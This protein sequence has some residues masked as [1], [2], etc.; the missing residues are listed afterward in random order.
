M[1]NFSVLEANARVASTTPHENVA[2]L[3][4]GKRH[5]FVAAKWGGKRWDPHC[6]D[7]L[8]QTNVSA[9]ILRIR[10][11]D[12]K[13]LHAGDVTGKSDPFCVFGCG[14]HD[15]HHKLRTSEA[16]SSVQKQTLNPVWNE[17]LMLNVPSLDETLTVWVWDWDHPPKVGLLLRS[18]SAF[19]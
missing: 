2:T 1:V 18:W 9:G 13:N 19:Y 6:A 5:A 7:S 17:T 10:L 16:M 14:R 11:I 12:G 4:R 15:K 3:S 8:E